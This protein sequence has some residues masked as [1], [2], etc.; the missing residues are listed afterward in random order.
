MGTDWDSS[1]KV[2]VIRE[3]ESSATF[4]LVGEFKVSCIREDG[5]D[6]EEMK[7]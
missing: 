2:S 4:L 5:F 6:N 1:N 7:R 3:G